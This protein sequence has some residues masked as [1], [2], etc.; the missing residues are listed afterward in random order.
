MIVTL[1]TEPDETWRYADEHTEWVRRKA[2]HEAVFTV[3][4]GLY[5]AGVDSSVVYAPSEVMARLPRL[6]LHAD[7]RVVTP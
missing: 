6:P 1:V 4:D 3:R 7:K 5:R 2:I